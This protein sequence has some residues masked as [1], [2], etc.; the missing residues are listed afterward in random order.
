MELDCLKTNRIPFY[1]LFDK[2][3]V[4]VDFGAH[5]RPNKDETKRAMERLIEKD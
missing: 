3:S 4:M 1:A 2:E 5:L